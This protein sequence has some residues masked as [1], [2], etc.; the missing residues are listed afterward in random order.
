MSGGVCVFS[1]L[2]ELLTIFKFLFRFFQELP[3]EAQLQVCREAAL[4]DVEA[5]KVRTL[6]ST[7]SESFLHNK[8]PQGILSWACA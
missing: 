2:H 8:S 6:S 3:R 1:A 4:E 7:T 5:G